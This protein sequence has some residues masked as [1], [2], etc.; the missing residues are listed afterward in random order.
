[1]LYAIVRIELGVFPLGIFHKSWQLAGFNWRL[2]PRRCSVK[3]LSFVYVED[4][5]F[6][7]QSNA[8]WEY[9]LFFPAFT[10]ATGYGGMSV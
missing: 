6:V 4:G 5:A 9:D 3:E 8:T 1:M 2:G 7:T 10:S